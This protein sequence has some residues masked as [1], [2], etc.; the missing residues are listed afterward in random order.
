M[1][2]IAIAG[3]IA[4]A[5]GYLPFSAL[6]KNG[7][8]SLNKSSSKSFCKMPFANWFVGKVGELNRVTIEPSL[9]SIATT[10]PFLLLRA[11]CAAWWDFKSRLVYKLLPIIG[12]EEI[13]SPNVLPLA[14]TSLR[15]LPNS[16]VKIS[17]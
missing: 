1:P 11:L 3:F 10:A 17:S 16:P 6:L 7:F 13:F 9:I 2:Y 15:L 14:S 5:G 4:E 8:S 12:A